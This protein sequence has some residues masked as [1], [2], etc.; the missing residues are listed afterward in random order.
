[1]IVREVAR[2]RKVVN[3]VG[4]GAAQYVIQ[5]IWTAVQHRLP[6]LYIIPANREYAILKEFA[7]ELHTAGVGH[8]LRTRAPSSADAGRDRRRSY[9]LNA[10]GNARRKGQ[11]DLIRTPGEGNDFLRSH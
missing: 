8:G 7:A 4:D 6:I 10:T 5:T 9:Q 3:I 11:V 2:H 1:M